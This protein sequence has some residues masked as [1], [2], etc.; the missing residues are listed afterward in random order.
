M[1]W[2]DGGIQGL[3]DLIEKY[4]E[5]ESDLLGLYN[6]DIREAIAGRIPLHVIDS[7]LKRL[8]FHPWSMFRAEQLG[9]VEHL[10]WSPDTY[11]AADQVDSTNISIAAIRHM[12]ARGSMKLPEPVYRPTVKTL[13]EK[14][15]E[16]PSLA[17]FPI[18]ALIAQMQ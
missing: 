1:G 18:H 14:I 4:P 7:L 5:V 9:G 11:L 2:A 13:E 10:G 17:D 16:A 8:P 6:V 3:R 12:G 15:E